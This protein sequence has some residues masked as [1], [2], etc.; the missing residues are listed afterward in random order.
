MSKTKKA[1]PPS[2]DLAPIVDNFES[3][4]AI[5][6]EL[7]ED[8]DR[9]VDQLADF[10]GRM[11]GLT[12]EIEAALDDLLAEFFYPK[13]RSND[14]G[15]PPYYREKLRPAFLN[16]VLRQGNLKSKSVMLRSLSNEYHELNCWTPPKF[17]DDLDDSR[18]FRNRLAHYP[19]AL[20]L[21]GKKDKPYLAPLLCCWDKDIELT[22]SLRNTKWRQ[23]E[24]V[25]NHIMKIRGN[26]QRYPVF[27]KRIEQ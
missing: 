2:F 17:F 26:I 7:E 22:P 13:V 5:V 6:E 19:F 27:E 4:L 10:R 11:V 23:F 9:L 25:R 18:D 24:R 14:A 8:R 3:D 16:F 12:Y 15:P 1:L 20:R 21:R